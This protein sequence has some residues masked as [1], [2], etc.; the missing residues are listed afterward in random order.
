[1]YFSISLALLIIADASPSR[2]SGTLLKGHTINVKSPDQG[3][4]SHEILSTKE[5]QLM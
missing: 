5:L 3:P 1:M 2:M 4:E